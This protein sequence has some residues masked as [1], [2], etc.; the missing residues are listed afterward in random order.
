MCGG[1]CRQENREND[2]EDGRWS[3]LS[4]CSVT[5]KVIRSASMSRRW[6]GRFN[7]RE[8]AG[9]KRSA[10]SVEGLTLKP[11]LRAP[12]KGDLVEP[13]PGC[14]RGHRIGEKRVRG[15]SRKWGMPEKV[16]SCRGVERVRATSQRVCCLSHEPLADFCAKAFSFP[17]SPAG[18]AQPQPFNER[19][20]LRTDNCR[21]ECKEES[22]RS[23]EHG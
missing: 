23:S 15:Q 6:L 1:R 8:G 22:H 21:C 13:L 5:S 17:P 18:T 14:V 7:E 3:H 4:P 19:I 12:E 11:S 16:S 10:D 2:S 20:S 9:R